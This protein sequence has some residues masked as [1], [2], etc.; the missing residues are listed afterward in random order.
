MV[1]LLDTPTQ[2][3]LED[4]KFVHDTSAA[5]TVSDTSV[6]D[7][8]GSEI[9]YTCNT[10]ATKIIYESTLHLWS[11]P[12]INN[13]YNIELYEDTGSGYTGLGDYHRVYTTATRVKYR[14]LINLRFVLPTYTGSR[15]YKLRVRSTGSGSEASVTKKD[16]TTTTEI[17]V[18]IVQMYSII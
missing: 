2:N 8:S 15:S 14:T 6:D 9:S 18:P 17:Y 11:N 1:Y 5:R 7:I 13:S 12:D 3:N 10:S 16:S 4:Q